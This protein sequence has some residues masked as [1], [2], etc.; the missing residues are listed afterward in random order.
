V[1]L[2]VLAADT[3]VALGDEIFGKPADRDAARRMLGRLSGV[4]HDVHTAVALVCTA[5]AD[6]RLNSSTVRF[7]T[8]TQAE[9]DWLAST[10]E[11]AD[12]AGAYAIQGRAALFVSRITGSYSGVMGLPLFETWE[13]LRANAGVE[14]RGWAA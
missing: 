6:V 11:P 7:R 9:I 8:L 4:T 10:D 3:T 12:K 5:G 13:L 2:P 14:L 1:R